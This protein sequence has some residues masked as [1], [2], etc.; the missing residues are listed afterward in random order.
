[1]WSCPNC[2]RIFKKTKQPHSCHKIPLDAHF[3]NKE[4]A[5]ELFD[6]LIKEVD[7]KIGKSQVISLPCCIHL[8]GKYDFLAVLP[9]KDSLE[10]RFTLDKKLNSKRIN[11]CVPMSA[12]VYKNC[13]E[14][15]SV[16]EID[17]ELIGWMNASYHLKG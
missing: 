5:R 14:L 7:E 6:H 3:R 16:K 17:D 12:K 15:S 2:N 11:Q 8:F 1:M 13:L 10:I 4:N 9:K